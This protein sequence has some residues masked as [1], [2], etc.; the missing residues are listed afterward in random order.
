MTASRSRCSWTPRWRSPVQTSGS[1]RPSS[2]CHS[3]GGRSSR[4]TTMPTWL[5]GLLVTVRMATSAAERPRN[6]QM[7]PVAAVATA[8]SSG[9]VASSTVR[10][11]RP[12]APAL[13]AHRR[14]GPRGGGRHRRRRR[15]PAP[16][17]ARLRP[18]GAAGAAAPA[19]GG[20]RQAG[21]MPEI[22]GR[23]LPFLR[24]SV[25]RMLLGFRHLTTEWQVG[26]GREDELAAYVLAQARPG[27]LDDAIRSVDEFC[28]RRSVMMNVGDEKGE[29]LDAAIRRTQPRRL[30]EL[31]TYCG[32]SALRTTRAM[33]RGAR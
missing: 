8:S 22:G 7:S 20:G 15:P 29:I 9:R 14:R 4:A 32:Y 26:D 23:R 25:W 33:P 3:S 16:R 17:A 18:G 2:A 1:E 31:G 19:L 28:Y 21:R 6:S 24:W 11:L 13:E 10:K 5:T 30:L 27:D 12:G